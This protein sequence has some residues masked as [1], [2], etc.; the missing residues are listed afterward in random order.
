MAKPQVEQK[1]EPVPCSAGCAAGSNHSSGSEQQGRL[2]VANT[3]GKTTILTSLTYIQMPSLRFSSSPRP[4]EW[5]A[6]ES[7]QASDLHKGCLLLLVNVLAMMRRSKLPGPQESATRNN[8]P[9]PTTHGQA[10]ILKVF[11]VPDPRGRR[12]RRH[13]QNQ[14]VLLEIDEGLFSLPHLTSRNP[15][16]PLPLPRHLRLLRSQA[17]A[18]G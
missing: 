13:A 10:G 12:S 11:I 16:L 7:S 2:G 17:N 3:D 9:G 8:F 5:R 1:H 6:F 18:I 15:P 4:P 14:D